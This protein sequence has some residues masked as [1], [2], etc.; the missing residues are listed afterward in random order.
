MIFWQAP[1][2]VIRLEG[3]RIKITL[4]VSTLAEINTTGPIFVLLIFVFMYCENVSMMIHY[5]KQIF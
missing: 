5:S 3:S 4:W 1:P 2:T